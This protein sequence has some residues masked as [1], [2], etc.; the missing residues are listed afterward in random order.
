MVEHPGSPPPPR[1]AI[2]QDELGGVNAES[3]LGVGS[4][5][6]MRSGM[7]GQAGLQFISR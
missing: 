7:A 6:N 4:G 5:W 2:D 1:S 3:M